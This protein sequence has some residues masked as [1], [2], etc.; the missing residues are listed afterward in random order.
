[1]ERYDSWTQLRSKI[2]HFD[3]IILLHHYWL[4]K[5]LQ[6]RLTCHHMSHDTL[7]T[8]QDLIDTKLSAGGE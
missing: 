6:N 4:Q 7:Q 3:S 2:N 8:Q 5:A 1:M